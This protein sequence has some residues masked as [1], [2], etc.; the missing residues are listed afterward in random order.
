MRAR[1]IKPQE[2]AA[3]DNIVVSK[4]LGIRKSIAVRIRIMHIS[5][6]NKRLKIIIQIITI[7]IIG[8]NDLKKT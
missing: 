5:V 2:I 6:I 3:T 7:S 8:D 1:N 4:F